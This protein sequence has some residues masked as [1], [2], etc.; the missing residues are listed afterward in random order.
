MIR[1]APRAEADW[2][3]PRVIAAPPSA[4]DSRD[5]V[6]RFVTDERG[7]TMIEYGMMIALIAIMVMG[8]LFLLGGSVSVKLSQ[9]ATCVSTRVCS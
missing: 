6:S 4:A 8:A 1:P 7:A 9:V 3:A 5:W 2:C